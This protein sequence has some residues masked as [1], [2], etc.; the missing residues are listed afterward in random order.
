[1]LNILFC[2]PLPPPYYGSAISSEMCLSI[3]KEDS[4]FR[5]VNVKLNYSKNLKDVGFFSLNKFF[6]F[7]ITIFELIKY[8]LF[9]PDIIYFVPATYGLPLLR[10]FIYLN[11]LNFNRKNKLVIH[12]RSRFL[13]IYS[14]SFFWRFIIIRFLKCD[15]VILVGNELRDN[16]NCYIDKTKTEIKILENAIPNSIN[17]KEAEDI[18]KKRQEGEILNMLFLSNMHPSK[19]WMH[20]LKTCLIL[21]K[22]NIAFVCHFAG[23]WLAKKDQVV[24]NNF[25][26]TYDLNNNIIY[27]G[28]L[29]NNQKKE[30]LI[31]SDILIFPTEYILE[32]FGRVIIEAMEFGLPV[33]S[34]KI[35]TIPSII[36]NGK[37]GFILDEITPERI[38]HYI[39]IL[40]KSDLSYQFGKNSRIRY[41]QKYS[42][43]IFR[44]NFKNIFNSIS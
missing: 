13:D 23:Q 18:I 6:G 36:I 14:E 25:V 42:I 39:S 9:K 8:K 5:V 7:F 16:I 15:V 28:Q 44:S 38:F 20:L 43:D 1:M 33:I 34:T 24:F 4:N 40:S 19:G 17:Q 30:L 22:N 3:L 35:G 10:D 29:L 32:T 11:I 12:L 31:K 2:S 37:T 21:K 27:H 26:N 41:V